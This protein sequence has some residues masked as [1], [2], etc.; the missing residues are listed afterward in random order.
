MD[1]AREP[2]VADVWAAADGWGGKAPA[3]PE[4]FLLLAPE[5]AHEPP[6]L[7]RFTLEDLAAAAGPVQPIGGWKPGE[8]AQWAAEARALR[9]H[10]DRR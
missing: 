8:E 4:W 9:E 5:A 10:M 1:D 6:P 7:K 3:W 2:K